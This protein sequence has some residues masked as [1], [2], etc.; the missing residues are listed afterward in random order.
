MK[1]RCHYFQSNECLR[2]VRAQSEEQLYTVANDS[3]LVPFFRV[4]V[5]PNLSLCF[6]S[7]CFG[8]SLNG[9]RPTIP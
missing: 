8:N 3:N 6:V 5:P 2:Y 4:Q 1:Q 7:V 9:R